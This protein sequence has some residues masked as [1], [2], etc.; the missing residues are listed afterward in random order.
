MKLMVDQRR[1]KVAPKV[2]AWD[3]F[4]GH[5]FSPHDITST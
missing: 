1:T 3:T 4:L 5:G 2:Q